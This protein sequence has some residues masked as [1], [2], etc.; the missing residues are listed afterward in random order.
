MKRLISK[1]WQWSFLLLL[2][3]SILQQPYAWAQTQALKGKVVDQ[4]GA[5]LPGVNVSIKGTKTGMTTNNDGR[6]TLSSTQESNTLVFTFV[7]FQDPGSCC[8]SWR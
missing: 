8:Q 3:V 7:G 4:Q 5:P 1:K 2:V 6:F